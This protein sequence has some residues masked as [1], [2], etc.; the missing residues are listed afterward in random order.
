[1]ITI[2]L[3]KAKTKAQKAKAIIEASKGTVFSC[4]VVTKNTT[5]DAPRVF[6]CRTGVK[7][8]LKGGKSPADGKDHLLVVWENNAKVTDKDGNVTSRGGYRTL[9]LNKVQWVC[10]RKRKFFL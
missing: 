2:D 7:K 8:N 10:V 4:A 5:P 3:S 9:N 6:N 1:M